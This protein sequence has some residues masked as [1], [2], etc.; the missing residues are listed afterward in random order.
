MYW[1][2]T[3]RQ[4]WLRTSSLQQRFVALEG[5]LSNIPVVLFVYCRPDI[6]Q[7]VLE[8]FRAD[9]VPLLYVLLR[10]S[11]SIKKISYSYISLYINTKEL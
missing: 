10:V 9:D 2:T 1:W 4:S 8:C 3:W 11:L 7:Q 5:T 6:L